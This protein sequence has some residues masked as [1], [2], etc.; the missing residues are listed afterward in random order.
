MRVYRYT[1]KVDAGARLHIIIIIIIK[2][3]FDG[4]NNSANNVLS[5]IHIRLYSYYYIIIPKY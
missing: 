5:Y 2:E 1:H 3:C 4:E